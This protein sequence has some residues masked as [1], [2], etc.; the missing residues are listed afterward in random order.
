MTTVRLGEGVV[1]SGNDSTDPDGEI[2]EYK[3]ILGGVNVLGYGEELIHR[4]PDA[5]NYTIKLQVKDND[6][7]T[8]S[9]EISISVS[10]ERYSL[11]EAVEAGYVEANITGITYM[12]SGVSSGDS[13]ILHIKRLVNYTIE[14]DTIPTGT[15]LTASGNA[16]NMAVLALKGLNGGLFYKPVDRIILDIADALEYLFSAYCV[17]FDKPNPT[18]E[19]TFYINEMADEEV[20]KVFKVLDD[21]PEDVAT[22]AAI[23][24]AIFVITDDITLEELENRF[25]SGLNQTDNARKILE[26]A[27]I[28][29]STKRLFTG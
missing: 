16:Q 24:T 29:I 27:G 5:G 2:V 11:S 18:K 20:L 19:T 7:L 21:L 28:D 12:L 15:L 14:I 6:G 1:L 13:I 10:L 8:D 25:P 17:D 23:Q 22:I 26:K 4:F 9:S 3:W